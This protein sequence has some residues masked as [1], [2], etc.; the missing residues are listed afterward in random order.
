MSTPT[1]EG[2]QDLRKRIL[3]HEA[4]VATGDA[5]ADEPP[6]TIE[7]MQVALEAISMDYERV[8]A[9]AKA[10]KPAASVKSVDLSDL[11]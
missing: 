8:D 11:L 3:E 4:K 6:Y 7:E 1:I 5:A 2:L 9:T 10:K